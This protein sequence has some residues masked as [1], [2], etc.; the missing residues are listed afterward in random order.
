MPFIEQEAKSEYKVIEGN[1]THVITPE[2]EVT[3]TNTV[4]GKEYF[5]DGEADAD[6]NDP[7]TATKKEH[8]KRDVTITV[9]D[10]KMGAD[11]NIED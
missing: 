5:S 11:F 1:K 3:L 6:V 4:T 2:C 10:I 8:I 9:E 7:N